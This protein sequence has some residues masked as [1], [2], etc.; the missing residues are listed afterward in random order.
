MWQQLAPVLWAGLGVL[1][2]LGI[3]ESIL[4]DRAKRAWMK[5]ADDWC[6]K[7]AANPPAGAAYKIVP[8]RES[9]SIF[10]AIRQWAAPHPPRLGS[11]GSHVPEPYRAEGDYIGILSRGRRHVVGYHTREDALMALRAY[12]K[13]DPL[14]EGACVNVKGEVVPC[15]V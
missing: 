12:L 2:I 14:P 15:V 8:V 9:G 1:C 5:D 6:E 10:Y 7:V 4:L 13:P 3:R 11:L